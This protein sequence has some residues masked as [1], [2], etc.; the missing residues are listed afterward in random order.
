MCLGITAQASELRRSMKL[1]LCDQCSYS[2]KE[3]Y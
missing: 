2:N 1:D 3:S